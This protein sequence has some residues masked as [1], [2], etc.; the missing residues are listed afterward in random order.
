MKKDLCP[1]IGELIGAAIA[2]EAQE[3]NAIQSKE[4]KTAGEI[5]KSEKPKLFEE[6]ADGNFP[7]EFPISE[8]LAEIFAHNWLAAIKSKCGLDTKDIKEDFLKGTDLME[9]NKPG[10]AAHHFTE[11]KMKLLNLAKKACENEKS[12]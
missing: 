8:P 3:H 12:P 6:L 5:I 10:L 4:W 11:A 7:V 1:C 2:I 9:E